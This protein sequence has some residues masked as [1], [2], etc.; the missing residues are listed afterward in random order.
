MAIG[1]ALLAAMVPH[2]AGWY[3]GRDV[4]DSLFGRPLRLAFDARRFDGSPRGSAGWAPARSS[5]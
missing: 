5:C 2:S 1:D 3:A 4:P